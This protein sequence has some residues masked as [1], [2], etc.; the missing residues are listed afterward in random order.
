MAARMVEL[1]VN[2]ICAGQLCTNVLHFVGDSAETNLWLLAKGIV[3]A[4]NDPADTSVTA[5]LW[6]TVMSE[7]AFVSSVSA[8]VLKPTPGT[9]A[10]IVFAV[11]DYPGFIAGE[12][13]S[14]SVA[15]VIKH[16]TASGPDFTGRTFL[17]AVPETW[18]VNG[19]FTD[20]ARTAYN[21]FISGLAAGIDADVTYDQV[22]YKRLTGTWE[23]VTNRQLNPNPGTI[24][25]RLLPV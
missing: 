21:Y 7:E 19:R 1:N 6:Q 12:I 24:R 4:F 25:K 5:G 17:P 13:Y 18:I 15:G 11:A 14:Q 2:T 20:A 23:L 16:V 9:K 22:I 10:I 3:D 8:R